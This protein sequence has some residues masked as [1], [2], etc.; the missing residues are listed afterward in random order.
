MILVDDWIQVRNLFKDKFCFGPLAVQKANSQEQ[1]TQARARNQPTH[2]LTNVAYNYLAEPTNNC[3]TKPK[4]IE[5]GYTK[6]HT[7]AQ[8]TW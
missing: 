8:E 7:I 6:L 5:N 4:T 3:S 2:W 1:F